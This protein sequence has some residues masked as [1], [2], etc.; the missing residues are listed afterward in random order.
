M[1]HAGTSNF[2][3]CPFNFPDSVLCRTHGFTD[4][5]APVDRKRFPPVLPTRDSF[6]S[7]IEHRWQ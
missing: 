6:E 4:M 7:Y 1:W 2:P 5:M 3:V